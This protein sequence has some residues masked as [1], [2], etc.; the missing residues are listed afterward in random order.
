MR[1]I[2]GTISQETALG[3]LLS[4]PILLTLFTGCSANGLIP[5][6]RDGYVPG[7]NGASLYFRTMGSGRD[8][9]V[10]V[11]GGPGAGMNTVIPGFRPLAEWYT[12][13]FYD[14]RGGGR[15]ELPADTTELRPE[16]FVEDLEAV[17]SHF[18]LDRMNVITHSFGSVLVAA[19]A[20][21][22]PDRL[23]RIVLHGATGPHQGQAVEIIRAKAEAAA[24]PADTALSRR[25]AELL[26]KLLDGTASDPVAACRE[27]ER[28][29]NRLA[30]L[31]GDRPY[32]A[33]TCDAPPEAVRYYY[34]YTAQLAPRYYGGWDFTTGLEQ[35]SAPVL[36]VYGENDSLAIPAQRAWANAVPNG[37]LLLVPDAGKAA[38]SENPE[39]VF[40]AIRTF[41]EDEWPEGTVM[42]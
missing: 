13:L 19:Y 18:R 35:L 11:H 24:P 15:S 22:Y 39:V 20:K 7:A 40:P 28:I 29:N 34:R 36:V 17:R 21:E 37:G 4:V 42:R 25:A 1:R 10:I 8:T 2:A 31:R 33:T 12:L 32:D 16:H 14:Q 26:G 6:V 5:G 38:V 3:L 30:V 9:L 41:F 27:Y 23:R